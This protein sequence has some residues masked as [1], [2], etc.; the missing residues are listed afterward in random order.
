FEAMNRVY[1]TYFDLEP[2]ARICVQVAGLPKR[3]RV[4]ITGIAYLG[5]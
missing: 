5:S 2:P 3:A 4:E 1:G